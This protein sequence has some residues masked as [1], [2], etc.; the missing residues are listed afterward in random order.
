LFLSKDRIIR[1]RRRQPSRGGPL[2]ICAFQKAASAVERRGIGRTGS[3]T[4]PHRTAE[5]TDVSETKT[6]DADVNAL[7]ADMAAL[8][9]DLA[10]IQDHLRQLGTHTYED[11]RDRAQ[12]GYDDVRHTAEGLAAQAGYQAELG[13]DSV[14]EA[15]R[16]R[17][18]ASLAAA[19]GLGL[20]FSKLFD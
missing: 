14:N 2:V 8:R 12:R 1:R 5:E 18:Y 15:V 16:Q 10:A 3:T 4:G 6:Q 19:F 11:A 7:K 13:I 20:I 17:P 9:A